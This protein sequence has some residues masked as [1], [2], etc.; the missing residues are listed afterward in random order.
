M[1][2]SSNNCKNL[3]SKEQI[4]HTFQPCAKAKKGESKEIGFGQKGVGRR[5][6]SAAPFS[7]CWRG[8][9]P[10][11]AQMTIVNSIGVAQAGKGKVQVGV[12]EWLLPNLGPTLARLF[13]GV[14]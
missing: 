5:H 14:P 3:C 6:A 7:S 8:S 4:M 1:G 9:C 11:V 10:D 2:K 12:T 13:T